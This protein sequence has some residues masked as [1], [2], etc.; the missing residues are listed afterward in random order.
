MNVPPAAA[1]DAVLHAM[2]ERSGVGG[3]GAH[4]ETAHGIGVKQLRKLDVGVFRVDRSDKGKT[5]VARLFSRARPHSAAEADLAVLRHLAAARFPAER[6]FEDRPLSIYQDQSVLLTEFIR[7]APK[8][9]RP[10]YP[11]VALGEMIGRLH[12]I[13]VPPA[14]DRPAGALHHF[15]Q[16]TMDDE[17]R[18][19]AGWLSAVEPRAPAEAMTAL[20]TLRSAVA[21]AEGG[22]GLPE[23]LVH[24]DPVPKNTIFTAEG[25]VLVDWTSAGR[26]PRLA[27][28]SLVLQSGWAAVPFLKGYARVIDLEESELD[29][30]AELLFSRGLM[31]LVFR[32]CLDPA[33]APAAARRLASLRRQTD[34]KAAEL[35][36]ALR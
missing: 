19:A 17:L 10:P 27:S 34:S 1:F 24:P 2:Y 4:L 15:A 32:V 20:A 16:G 9:K 28:M 11:I 13:P 25:P 23:A 8:P 29:H 35:I 7:P 30:L 3:L 5:A 33:T 22:A 12:G 6:P 14:A 18:A 36:A 26:G 31:S 21:S